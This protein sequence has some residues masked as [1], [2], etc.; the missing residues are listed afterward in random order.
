MAQVINTNV[1][2]LNAQRNL[3]SSQM[4]LSVSLQRLSSGLRVNSAK[5]DSAGLAIA[6]RMNAQI[7]GLNV[8]QRNASDGI[9]L[10]Q[11]AEGATGKI[12][13]ALQR[14]RELA[15]QSKN[16]TNNTNDRTN[17]Q[18]EFSQ[19]QAEITRVVGGTSFNGTA[20][21]NAAT[22]F[23]FQVGAGNATQD[24][25]TVTAVDLSGTDSAVAGL[26]ISGATNAGA[27]AA[28]TA[29]DTAI[30]A[31]TSARATWG[32]AQNRFESVIANLQVSTEN[33]TSARSR[34][35]DAD[36]AVETANLT[37]SSI[38]QQAG[39]AMLA[40]ANALPNNVLT[41]LRG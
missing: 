28:I 23:S 18:A 40:Q 33:I 11:T 12:G 1:G 3:T 34:I 19:L 38:L 13:E 24:T 39:T 8:A 2:S 25:I 30:D 15:V 27:T 22:A 32:A 31:V 5:D 9:S 20:L 14:M 7:R 6:E 10:A 26:D 29:L 21:L 37:R 4:S 16:D 36:F 17:L 35:M 41:L